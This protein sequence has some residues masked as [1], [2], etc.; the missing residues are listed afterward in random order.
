MSSKIFSLGD[1]CLVTD[2]VANGSFASLKENVEYEP[3]GYAVLVRFTDF[4][5]GWN[6]NYK[7]ISKSSYEFLNKSKLFP[8]DLIVTNVGYPGKTFILPDLGKPMSLAPNALLVRPDKDILNNYYLKYLIDS[9]YGQAL[10]ESISSGAAQIKFNKTSFRAINLPLPS[11]SVQKQ[12][13]EKLDAA[14]ADI[15]KAISATEK[16]IE[17]AEALF[18]SY[19]NQIFETKGEGWES[20][21]IEEAFMI[22]PP[23][24]EF[25]EFPLNSQVSFMGMNKLGI[26]QKYSI[27]EEVRDLEK[28]FKNY[29]YF[30]END[31]LLAKITP[32]FENGKLGIAKEL[33]N[34]IGFGSSEF[35]V[36]RTKSSISNEWLYYFL[37]RDE[38]RES[39]KKVMTGAVGHKRVPKEF[40][41]KS[42]INF[43]KLKS[44]EYIITNFESLQEKTSKLK[45]LSK[46][47]INNLVALK[48][49]LLNQA[50]SGELT[51]DAA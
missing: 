23:K 27:P 4:S 44:Q 9:P 43:P 35:V 3:D 47:K 14:F 29:T 24:S 19:L 10:I 31:V 36:L 22:K 6:G 2:Y 42:V 34:G 21:T 25:K 11:I 7:F 48:S 16:N 32:C 49:S 38:F 26:N 15:D 50:F 20:S 39:G 41:E 51:K 12:I 37:L 13:V 1:I 8:E 46:D 5:K 45:E 40:I 28:V 30:S 18:Q 17:N 33:K